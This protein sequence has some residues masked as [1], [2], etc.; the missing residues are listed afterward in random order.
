MSQLRIVIADD[1]TMIR[2]GLR[3][4]LE[5]RPGWVICA[6][7]TTGRQAVEHALKLR[8]DIAI[9]DIS[10][11]EL[12]GLEATRQIHQAL[13]KT[14]VLILTM[15]DSDELVRAVVAAGAHGYLLK[16]DAG[17][18]L[19]DAVETLSQ[20]K[21]YF[22]SRMEE[23]VSSDEGKPHA[24]LRF[25][26]RVTPRERQIIQLVAEGRSCKEVAQRLGISVKTAETHRTNIMRKLHLHNASEL[27]RY[28][29]RNQFVQP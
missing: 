23:I 27:V 17:R 20:H 29:I 7:A 1:H 18:L 14:E 8:P 25:R 15:H 26:E 22:T 5:A 9:L 28:A 19:V 13:P 11:P 10:M 16:T 21:P 3:A 4:S 24:I 6:E 2:E 12:N